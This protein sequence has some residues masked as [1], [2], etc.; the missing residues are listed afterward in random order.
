MPRDVFGF[1]KG[2]IL[3][4]FKNSKD[5]SCKESQLS[6]FRLW[7][8]GPNGPFKSAAPTQKWAQKS[9]FPSFSDFLIMIFGF[10]T[11]ENISECIYSQKG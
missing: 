1:Y 11:Q 8:F 7:I 5:I 4:H 10:L 2:F 6:V 3:C 9:C